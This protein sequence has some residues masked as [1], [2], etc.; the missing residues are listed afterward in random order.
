MHAFD[1]TK[2]V[3]KKKK[4]FSKLNSPVI[5]NPA[6]RCEVG[7]PAKAIE[8]NVAP[9]SVPVRFINFN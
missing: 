4:N 6:V 1:T 9:P 7:E 5:S 3:N 2:E 8:P